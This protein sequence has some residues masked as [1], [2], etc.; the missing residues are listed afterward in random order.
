MNHIQRLEISIFNFV[1]KTYERFLD[2]FC[3]QLKKNKQELAQGIFNDSCYFGN[4]LELKLIALP[5][6]MT[7]RVRVRGIKVNVNQYGCSV[8]E[9]AVELRVKS[10]LHYTLSKH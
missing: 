6:P 9:R 1:L 10:G 7:Q 5:M 8:T 2:E 4:Y 3:S